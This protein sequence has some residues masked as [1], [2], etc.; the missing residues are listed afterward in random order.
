MSS[1][2]LTSANSVFMLSIDTL[3]T[4]AQ[5]LQGFSTDDIFTTSEVKPAEIKM[6]ADGIMSGGWLPT[7]QTMDIMLQADSQS[8]SLFD[9]WFSS[10]ASNK[11]L[12]Y[13][14][15]NITLPSFLGGT[16]FVLSKGIL[17][18]YKPIPDAK[19]ILQPRTFGISWQSI[20]PAPI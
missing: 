5:Q 3:Y 20:L 18:K 16:V 2:S 1:T 7:I 8:N 13:A 4:T 19:T 12:Y 14:S 15:G 17:H 10:Q 11:Q 6:G 9:T